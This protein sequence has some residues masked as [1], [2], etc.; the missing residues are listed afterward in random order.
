MHSRSAALIG[1]AGDDAAGSVDL[2]NVLLRD[3]RHDLHPGR[4][5][6]RAKFSGSLG[7]ELV[8]LRDGER[9]RVQRLIEILRMLGETAVV[10]ADRQ[11]ARERNLLRRHELYERIADRA[12]DDRMRERIE[13]G[14]DRLERAELVGHVRGRANPCWL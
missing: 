12:L 2:A 1:A 7:L 4:P 14:V 6:T 13:A 11:R 5:G 10:L 3:R 9:S 8:A